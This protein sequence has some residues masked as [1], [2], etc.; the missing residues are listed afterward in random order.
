MDLFMNAINWYGALP[1]AVMIAIGIFL[2]AIIVGRLKIL[3]AL[4]AAIYVGGGMVGINTMTGMFMGAVAP[5]LSTMVA[6]LGLNLDV[7]DLGIGSMQASVTF[8]MNF[9]AILLPIGLAVNLVM[10]FT[11]LTDTFD[12]DIFNY[13]V[14]SLSAGFIMALT[15]NLALAIAAFIITEVVC[16][17]LAD[18]TQPA[19]EEA[20][21][22]VGVSIPHGNAV[23][24]AP[25]GMAVNAVIEKIPALAKIDWSPELIE[26]KFGGLVQPSTIGFVVGI[27]FGIGGGLDFGGT[28]NL[29]IT[30]AAFMIIFP[31]VL[32]TLIEGIQP[33]ADGM[34][35]VTEKKLNRDLHIG[36]DAAVLVGMPDVMATG[37]LLT[38]VTLLLA[39]ILPG[40]RVMP[41][42]DLAIACPFLISCCM[43]YCKKNIFRGFICGLVV[44]TIAFYVCTFTAEAYT[45]VAAMNGLPFDSISTS[46]G[47]SST[48]L[49]AI[50]AAIGG[51]L[52]A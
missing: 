31:K 50:F 14:W 21:G 13:F 3:E 10:I 48:W 43:P 27:G 12:V 39:F 26:E 23:V 8:P 29:A 20:Y 42:A 19:I 33:V 49:S 36:L 5:V 44:M 30:I 38:P 24:F 17:K 2:V 34:R 9:Y 7:L 15:S 18:I 45:A 28:V 40:N 25:V 35:E 51:V 11:K 41:M 47:G 6:N 4:K 37:I 22:L 1:S 46:L 32:G 52:G 16:L